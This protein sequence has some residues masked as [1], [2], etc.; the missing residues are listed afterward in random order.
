MRRISPWYAAMAVCLAVASERSPAS[1]D[2]PVL[3]GV[4]PRFAPAFPTA[5]RNVRLSLD[6]IDCAWRQQS[7]R[8]VVRPGIID[9]E[10][11]LVWHGATS[12]CPTTQA[13]A[14]LGR[15]APGRYRWTTRWNWSPRYAKV[16]YTHEFPAVDIVVTPPLGE[17][18]APIVIE[19]RNVLERRH[20][21][22]AADEEIARLDGLGAE[23]WFRTGVAFKAYAPGTPGTVPVCR[24]YAPTSADGGGNTHTF[25]LKHGEC[26]ASDPDLPGS[27]LESS[28]AFR[29]APLVAIAQVAWPVCSNVDQAWIGRFRHE[30]DTGDRRY[31]PFPG[32][33]QALDLTE[34]EQRVDVMCAPRWNCVL[35]SPPT[36]CQ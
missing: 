4:E 14:M 6:L 35:G 34:W 36:D 27:I 24:Y 12:P 10:I 32:G 3:D 7:A 33:L 29:A 18:R 17:T 28:D 1:S 16:R 25:L 11:D 8:V 30:R 2:A 22:T 31:L 19:Y 15:L 23:G 21:I 20:F 26:P 9:F 5:D 13:A